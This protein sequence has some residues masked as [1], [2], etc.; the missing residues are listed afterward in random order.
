MGK[1]AHTK[2]CDLCGKRYAI[3]N[4]TWHVSHA[5]RMSFCEDCTAILLKIVHKGKTLFREFRCER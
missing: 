1:Y 2:R 4:S 5:Y 3:L